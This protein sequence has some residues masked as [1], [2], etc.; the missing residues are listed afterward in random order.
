MNGLPPPF[1]NAH[2][3][4]RRTHFDIPG[5]R[6]CVLDVHPFVFRCPDCGRDCSRVCAF[7]L[8]AAAES[9]DVPQVRRLMTGQFHH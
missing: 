2:R 6:E 1:C 8:L 7:A 3:A 4:W 9:R 5:L